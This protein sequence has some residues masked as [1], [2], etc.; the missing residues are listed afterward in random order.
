VAYSRGG[1]DSCNVIEEEEVVLH[2]R[3][4]TL[5]L[6]LAVAG[7]W[8]AAA[9]ASAPT[10][11]PL[12][13]GTTTAIASTPDRTWAVT[14]PRPVIKGGVWRIARAFD[15]AVVREQTERTLATGAVRITFRTV[16]PGTTRVVF[17]LTRGE[18]AKAYAARIFK[19]TVGDKAA[20]GR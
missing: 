2:A 19:F 15:A 12:P 8:A 10:V 3:W 18:T 17:A 6:G 11:G 5:V 4:L 9:G 7:S 14:L 13:A 1:H 16:G 20:P